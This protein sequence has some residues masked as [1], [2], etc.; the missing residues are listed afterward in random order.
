MYSTILRF[1]FIWVLVSA[2]ISEKSFSILREWYFQN[3]TRVMHFSCD[4]V[5]V[6]YPEGDDPSN[7]SIT[8]YSRMKQF[9]SWIWEI[10]ILD[11]LDRIN[12]SDHFNERFD[13]AK[14]ISLFCDR[15]DDDRRPRMD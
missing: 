15:F 12:Q 14:D 5:F 2:E 4:N 8:I 10:T 6:C 3:L 7:Y 1:S 11:N 13:K 9:L